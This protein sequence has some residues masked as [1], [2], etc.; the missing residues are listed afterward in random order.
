M[1]VTC[2][3]FGA[4]FSLGVFLQPMAEAMGWSRTGISTAAL[5]NFL[6]M[7]VGSFFWGDLSDRLGTRVV[8]LLGGALLGLGTVMPS[9]A[10]TLEGRVRASSWPWRAT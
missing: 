5:L 1:V 3:G 9:R 8:V 10:S 7:G 2:V 6:C 4:M